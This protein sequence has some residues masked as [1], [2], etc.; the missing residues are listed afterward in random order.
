MGKVEDEGEWAVLLE[1][2]SV[3]HGK[4]AQNR[5]NKCLEK[6]RESFVKIVQPRAI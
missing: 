5:R 4:T 3:G 1:G 6:E 2:I